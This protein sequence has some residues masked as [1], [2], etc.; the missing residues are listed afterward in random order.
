M[1]KAAK[2]NAARR[3]AE[4]GAGAVATVARPVLLPPRPTIERWAID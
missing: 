1:G 2:L 3:A 4:Q